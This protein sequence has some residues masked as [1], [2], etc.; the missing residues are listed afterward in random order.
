VLE[1]LE[2]F[3]I[4]CQCLLTKGRGLDGNMKSGNDVGGAEVF[5]L[6]SCHAAI[7]F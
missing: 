2:R 6:A 5:S 3:G 7:T 4:G 1:E